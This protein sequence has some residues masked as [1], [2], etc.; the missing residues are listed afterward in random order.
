MNFKDKMKTLF[1]YLGPAFIVSVA[2]IDPGNFATNISAGS[3]YNYSL[4]WVILISNLFAI[5]LQSLSAKL[6]IAT[7]SNLP[8]MCG[9]VFSQ[10]TNIFLWLVAQA[11]A[12]ATNL[13]EFLG[14]TLGLY[15]LFKIPIFLAGIITALLTL[16]IIYLGRYGQ[17][18]I[19]LTIVILVLVICIC[20]FTEIFLSKPNWSLALNGLIT[21]QIKNSGALL[22]ATGMLGATVM[23]HVIFLHSELVQ[24][25]NHHK[26]YKEKSRH[27][28]LEKTDIFIAMNIAFLVNAAMVIV[29]A[30]VFFPLGIKV[31]SIEQ[32]H[33]A[34]SPLLGELSAGAFGVALLASGLSSSAVGTM[35]GQTIIQGFIKT[36]IS[37]N[38]TRIISIAPAL[39][40]I[41]SGFNPFSALILSQVTLSFVLPFAVIPLMLITN[42]AE[43]MGKFKN[44]PLTNVFG[45]I[46]SGI[47]ILLNIFLLINI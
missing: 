14:S 19:E 33:I 44:K 38:V 21:P 35:A 30:A 45:W 29:S 9:R 37:D 4:L 40:I 27:L 31:E 34:L 43:I 7:N 1:K 16:L 20:F 13:A 32:A 15:L 28:L 47:I 46:V 41:C 26:T 17:R 11:A 36:K 5:F 3:K 2:Y 6:G 23:P 22:I 25:R 42:N 10:R 12:I 39:L 18:V 8:Q 24:Y